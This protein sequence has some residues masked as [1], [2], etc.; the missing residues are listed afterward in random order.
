MYRCAIHYSR[1][2]GIVLS[3]FRFG[4]RYSRTPC[5]V[6]IAIA[7]IGGHM[8]TASLPHVVGYADRG[9]QDLFRQGV[10]GLEYPLDVWA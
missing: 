8:P 3:I 1:R 4:R 6:H 9:G 2:I 10:M 7:Y 5:R